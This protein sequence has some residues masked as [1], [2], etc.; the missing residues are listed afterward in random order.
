[1]TGMRRAVALIVVLLIAVAGVAAWRTGFFDATRLDNIR[2]VVRAARDVPFAPALFVVAY[3]LAV[4]LLLPTTALALFGGALFGMPALA[5]TW[6]GAM[7]GTACAF[8]LGRYTGRRAVKRFLGQHTLLKRLRDDA[9][10]LDLMRLRVLPVAPF[11]VLDYLAGMSAI[12][13]RPLLLATGAAILLPQAAYV[14]AGQQLGRALE[15]RG[16]AKG[17]L[18]AAGV[19]TMVLLFAAAAPTVVKVARRRG[20]RDALR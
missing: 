6:I 5:L 12:R 4:L 17:A 1:M 13:L 3:T 20:K 14:L 10:I 16:S 11:G 2:R 18:L 8:L 15:G 19:V 9:S 7:V